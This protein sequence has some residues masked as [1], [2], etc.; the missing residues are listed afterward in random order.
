MTSIFS[1]IFSY[2]QSEGRSPREDFFTETFADVVSKS[3]LFKHE[4][5]MWLFELKLENIKT[6]RIETQK[7]FGK[8]RP[9]I[10]VEV[11]DTDNKS[12]VAII[13]SKIDSCVGEGQLEAYD[14]ILSKHWPENWSKTL[15]FITKYNED[16]SDY[17]KSDNIKFRQHKWSEL[18]QRFAKAKQESSEE[19]GALEHELLE[20]LEDW[21]MDGKINATHLRSFK[22]C[23]DND[24]YYGFGER[25][26]E[27]PLEAWRDSGLEDNDDLEMEGNWTW[28]FAWKGEHLSYKIQPYGIKIRMGFRCSRRDADWNVDNLEIPSP[29]VMIIS[30]NGQEFPQPNN[31]TNPISVEGWTYGQ[32]IR[33][34]TEKDRPIYGDS[35]DEF[36]KRFFTKAFDEIK[37]AI[38][39]DQ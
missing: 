7:P 6:N 30:G 36:Y 37:Q 1:R 32:W 28:N 11:Q 2:R 27:I 34:P 29:T 15:V 33:Q 26:A 38:E 31:W 19:V 4:F 9:D 22:T 21:H 25:L 14:N 12:H 20:L 35:L 17:E 3:N 8:R 16:V 18:H 24:F 5:L 13:E 10:C 23:F 39:C